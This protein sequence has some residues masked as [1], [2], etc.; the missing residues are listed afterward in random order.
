MVFAATKP[1]QMRQKE[2]KLRAPAKDEIHLYLLCQADSMSLLWCH[3]LLKLGQ[4][5]IW[6]KI[7]PFLGK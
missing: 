2:T 4:M 6:H 5:H 7:G 3:L 1:A